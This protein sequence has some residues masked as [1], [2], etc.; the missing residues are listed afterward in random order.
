MTQN[1]L[2]VI[3]NCVF[4]HFQ[5]EFSM[6]DNLLMNYFLL[7][8]CDQQENFCCECYLIKLFFEALYYLKMHPNFV[9]SLQNLN[10]GYEKFGWN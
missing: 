7:R 9:T 5:D 2:S 3:E 6:S 4:F 1:L 10:G 8:I